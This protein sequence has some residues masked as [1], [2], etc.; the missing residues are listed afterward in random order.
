MRQPLIN[1]LTRTSNRP[2][3]F[4]KNVDNIRNQTYKN[5]NHI[6]CTDDKNSIQYIEENGFKDYLF[7]DRNNIIKKDN[8]P[9]PQT[10]VY[11]PHNLYFNHMIKKVTDGWVIYL[12]DDDTFTDLTIVEKIVDEINK[13]DEDTLIY[14]RMIYSNGRTLPVNMGGNSL[15]ILGG[16]GGSCFTFHSKYNNI[17]MWDSWKCGDYRLICKLHNK[18]PNKCWIPENF[19]YVPTQG[20]GNRKDIK[21]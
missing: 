4:K 1:I 17:A 21:I 9:N 20:M 13:N 16:I 5:I 19:I 14:W 11:S 15:P 6:I 7:L 10:G 8:C 18:I 2:I 3:G 12:D